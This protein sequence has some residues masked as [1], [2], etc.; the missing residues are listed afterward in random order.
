MKYFRSILLI[1]SII[2]IYS[3]MP[4]YVT[5]LQQYPK[6]YQQKPLSILVL[7]PINQST[8]AEAKEYYTS[9]ITECLANVGYYVLPIAITNDILKQE[10]AW[11][12]EVMQSSALTKFKEYFGADAVLLTKIISWNKVYLI[13]SGSVTVTLSFTLLSTQTPDTLWRYSGTITKNTSG[14]SNSGNILAD[15]ITSAIVTAVNTAATRYVDVA[16]EVNVQVLSAMPAGKYND[17]FGLDQNDQ[18]VKPK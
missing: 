12:T 10:G 15:L 4:Q 5:K 8:S 9:T 7:P 16:K 2:L 14:N 6:M 17:R 18:I 11:D 13:T 3:C 1:S